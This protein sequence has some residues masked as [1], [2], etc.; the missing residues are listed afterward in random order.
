MTSLHF[1]KI[2]GK[3]VSYPEHDSISL[4]IKQSLVKNIWFVVNRD[5]FEVLLESG[6]TL[7]IIRKEIRLYI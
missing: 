6:R 4:H 7:Y 2:V 1:G 3:L 5:E